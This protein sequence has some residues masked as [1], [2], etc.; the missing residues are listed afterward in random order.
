MYL[1]LACICVNIWC[2]LTSS[3]THRIF[4]LA[5]RYPPRYIFWWFEI[6]MAP[7]GS[8]IWRLSLLGVAL[9]EDWEVWPC[10]GRCCCFSAVPRRKPQSSTNP[11]RSLLGKVKDKG[12]SHCCAISGLLASVLSKTVLLLCCEEPPCSSTAGG[13]LAV[14][15]VCVLCATPVCCSD[16]WEMPVTLSALW[17]NAQLKQCMRQLWWSKGWAE[18]TGMLLQETAALMHRLVGEGAGW[19]HSTG[20]MWPPLWAQAGWGQ[21]NTEILTGVALLEEVCHWHGLWGFKTQ[22]KPSD[23]LFLLPAD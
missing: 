15:L 17:P 7:A 16:C 14:P 22:V 12:M 19:E 4:L 11:R 3:K 1:T 13:H 5:P 9:L 10:Y 20:M 6:H 21:H 18:V 2:L 23:F 8:C